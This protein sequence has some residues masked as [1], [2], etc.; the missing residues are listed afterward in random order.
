MRY[1][2]SFP[3]AI[4]LYGAGYPRVTHPSA[5]QSSLGFDRNLC[6]GV[7]VRLACVRHAASVH[8]E[9]GSNSQLK[10]LRPL[11]E[12]FVSLRQQNKA[13]L[14]SIRY[15]SRCYLFD[16]SWSFSELF[17]RGQCPSSF[18]ALYLPHKEPSGLHCCL[19][20]MV[21]RKMLRILLTS[22]LAVHRFALHKSA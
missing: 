7:F 8:P 12:P 6:L 14:H 22:F 11:L 3:T 18:D 10:S 20:V 16:N 13:A 4:P 19:F 9:P 5:T 17:S 1:Y 21:R 2:Q 15:T